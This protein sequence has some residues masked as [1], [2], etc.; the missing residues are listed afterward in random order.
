VAA[1]PLLLLVVCFVVIARR[2]MLI[3]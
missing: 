3:R 1:L 2:G